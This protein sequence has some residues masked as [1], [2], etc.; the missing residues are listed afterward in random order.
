MGRN[1][2]AMQRPGFDPSVGEIPWRRAWD[3]TPVFL[4]GEFHG[5]RNLV[6]YSPWDHKESGTA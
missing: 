3:P 2:P 4:R 5:Q 1:L 6:S